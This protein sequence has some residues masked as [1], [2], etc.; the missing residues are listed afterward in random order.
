MSDTITINFAASKECPSI[1]IDDGGPDFTVEDA[2]NVE[3]TQTITVTFSTD[4]SL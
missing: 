2:F 3:G 1:Q 4:L